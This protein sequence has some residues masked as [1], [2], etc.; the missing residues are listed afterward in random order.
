MAHRGA[1]V[2]PAALLLLVAIVGGGCIGSGA[3]DEGFAVYLPAGDVGIQGA[4]VSLGIELE[5][6]PLLSAEGIIAYD[7]KTHTIELTPEAHARL[8][9]VVLAEGRSSCAWAV[10]PCMRGHSYLRISAAVSR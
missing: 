10:S 7:A 2:I 6:E 8:D 5:E 1:A 9:P 3:P 4:A